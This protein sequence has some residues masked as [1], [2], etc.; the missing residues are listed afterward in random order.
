MPISGWLYGAW[1]G[2]A[3]LAMAVVAVAAAGLV[4][5]ADRPAPMALPQEER[6]PE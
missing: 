5:T 1:G 3:F 2:Q 4:A 6:G